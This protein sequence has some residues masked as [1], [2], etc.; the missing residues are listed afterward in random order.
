MVWRLTGLDPLT[1]KTMIII[2][3]LA[4]AIIGIVVA[5]ALYDHFRE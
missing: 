1:R 2:L 3:I 5:V 4:L